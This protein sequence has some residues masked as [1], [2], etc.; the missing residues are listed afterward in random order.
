LSTLTYGLLS[1][2]VHDAAIA[3]RLTERVQLPIDPGRDHVFTALCPEV[4][5]HGNRPVP[6]T[7]GFNETSIAGLRQFRKSIV[8]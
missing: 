4:Q 5:R 8:E 3:L 1:F 7:G 2:G 6:R